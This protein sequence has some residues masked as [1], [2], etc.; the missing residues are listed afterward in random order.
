MFSNEI[1]RFEMDYIKS[2]MYLLLEN[3]NALIVDPNKSS[4][5]ISFYDNNV[6]NKVTV[7]LT[8][9]HFD[10]TTGVNILYDRYDTEVICTVE[11]SK[12]IADMKCNRPM[13]LMGLIG[14]YSKEEIM[15]AYRAIGKYSCKSD[16]TFTGNMNLEWNGHKLKL[17]ATPGH[18]KGSCCIEMDDKFIFTGDSL[19]PEEQVITGFPG[20]SD[21]EYVNK[22]L[23]FL[24][25][26]SSDKIIMPGHGSP[27]KM[28]ELRYEDGIF[29]KS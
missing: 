15:S 18:S 8:H 13:A 24:L 6:I 20:G 19:V 21:D 26:I 14:E 29:I 11:C 12:S 2:N 22:T 3:G 5:A 25:T 1:N 4:S 28:S 9:E 23:P 17:L 10:H 16:V 7:I 27:C